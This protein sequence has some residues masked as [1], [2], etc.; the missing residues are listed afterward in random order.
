MEETQTQERSLSEEVVEKTPWWFISMFLHAILFVLAA[1]AIV[2]HRAPGEPDVIVV[3]PPKV[4]DIVRVE[5]KP[6]LPDA[7]TRVMSEKVEEIPVFV[8]PEAGGPDDEVL[9]YQSA[10]QGDPTEMAR[11]PFQGPAVNSSIGLTGG[12]GGIGGRKDSG[13]RSLKVG[14]GGGNP[15]ITEAAVLRALRWL[16][17]HQSPDGSWSG[18]GYSRH[19]G[20]L[21][22]DCRPHGIHS[23]LED[24]AAQ[25]DPGRTGLALLAFLGAGYTSGSRERYDG[26]CMGDV[27]RRATQYLIRAQD[28]DGCIGPREGE[29]MYNHCLGALALVES[30]GMNGSLKLRE[31]AQKA[32]DF[33]VAAQNPGS[34]W[35]YLYQEGEADTSV[36]GWAVMVLKSADLSGLDFDHAVYDGAR[37]WL[38]RSSHK[39]SGVT[40]AARWENS[41]LEEPGDTV[42][43]GVNDSFGQHPT[44][45]AVAVMCRLFMDKKRA[46]PKVVGGARV[47]MDDLPSMAAPAAVDFYYWYCAS[48]ALFQQDAPDGAMWRKW[49]AA[50]METLVKSQNTAPDQDRDGSWEP[51]DRWSCSGGRVYATAINALTLEVY[52]R[53]ASV[54]RRSAD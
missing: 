22:G 24:G 25:F 14:Q 42:I 45:T 54:V 8:K 18:T 51:V 2:I 16:S 49:N 10:P 5:Q 52:Y 47:L 34:G 31:P 35:R 37:A 32:V 48:L 38:E 36:T 29:Y 13:A 28:A 6:E 39:V 50:M 46:D 40:G 19:C 9:E 44:M 11:K 1:L 30:Y 41:Y 21:K 43:P 15:Q 12:G 33:L 53:Y 26:I 7:P 20:R 17:R 4:D 23:T 27:V 3:A